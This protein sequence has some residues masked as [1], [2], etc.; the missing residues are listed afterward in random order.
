MARPKKTT[1]LPAADGP[2]ASGEAGTNEA[3]VWVTPRKGSIM[4]PDGVKIRPGAAGKIP[5]AD[6]ERYGAVAFV[7]SDKQA[8]AMQ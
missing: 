7:L 1:M 2:P 6:A 8:E 5:A 4:T 3:D